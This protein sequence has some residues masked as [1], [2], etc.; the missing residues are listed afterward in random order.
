M[1][2]YTIENQIGKITI[3]GD[4]HALFGDR[5]LNQPLVGPGSASRR[6]ANDV[7]IVVDQDLGQAKRNVS[8]EQEFQAA[9]ALPIAT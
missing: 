4:D 2:N 8:V 9:R 6:G 1:I 3:F 7:M 5:Q